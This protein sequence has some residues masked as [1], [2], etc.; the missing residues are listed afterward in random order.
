LS[1]ITGNPLFAYECYLRLISKYS[2]SVMGFTDNGTAP[3]GEA[4]LACSS[5]VEMRRMVNRLLESVAEATGAQFPQNPR[6]QIIGAL[7]A[8]FSS[9][10]SESA[11]TYR[12]I[13][14][15]P[16][17]FGTAATIQQ[18]VFGNRGQ[19]SCSGVVFSRNPITGERH[20]FGEYLPCSQ[21][22]VLVSGRSTP[23][24]LSVG[25]DSPNPS[26]SLENRFPH[27]YRELEEAVRKLEFHF[28]DAQDI[29]FTVEETVLYLLQTRPAKR[30]DYAALKTAVDLVHEGII[31]KH[32]AVARLQEAGLKQL[33]MPVFSPSAPKRLI[34]R[35]NPASPGVATGKL[36][37]TRKDVLVRAQAGEDIILVTTRTI[38]KDIGGIAASKGVLTREGGMTSHAA[39]NSRRMAKPCVTGCQ[40]LNI[41][42]EAQVL[43]LNSVE[44]GPDDVI[45]IDGYSGEVFLGTVEII[46]PQYPEGGY[47]RTLSEFEQYVNTYLEWESEFSG[48]T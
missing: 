19:E 33:F 1:R 31:D 9:W 23:L 25:Q 5:P 15:I 38:P 7:S 37:F 17:H 41:D 30:T 20:I 35:G 22:E 3:I 2:S 47:D 11:I 4:E 21:G 48:G 10:Q 36:A 34:A 29:E 13:F 28:R 27:I 26:L 39:I 18:M 24:P 46:D 45:S 8:I 40:A 12:Q 6:E 43:R 16:H 44:L 32:A 42:K 14:N